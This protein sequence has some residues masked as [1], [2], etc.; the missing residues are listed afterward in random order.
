MFFSS[1]K[2]G[3]NAACQRD[4]ERKMLRGNLSA[5]HAATT[6]L[7]EIC[8]LATV[9]NLLASKMSQLSSCS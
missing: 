4:E 2:S 9:S 8:M 1:A 6:A 5:C 3:A 7:D